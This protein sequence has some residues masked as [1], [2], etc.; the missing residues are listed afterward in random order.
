MTVNM[1]G[2][3][4]T[5]HTGYTHIPVLTMNNFLKWKISQAQDTCPTVRLRL[6]QNF[7]STAAGIGECEAAKVIVR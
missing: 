2:D 3:S 5:L 1:P 7:D 4:T 6:R